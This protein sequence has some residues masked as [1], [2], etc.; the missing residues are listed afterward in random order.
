MTT[1]LEWGPVIYH[2]SVPINLINMQNKKSKKPLDV[3]YDDALN[4]LTPAQAT[5]EEI[6]S[7]GRASV[8]TARAWI[9]GKQKPNKASLALLSAYYKLPE[10]KLF[11]PGHFDNI[12]A[13]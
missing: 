5:L 13:N 7:V 11:S 8:A 4:A 9:S 3:L 6:A 10:D 1:T 2:G 12:N